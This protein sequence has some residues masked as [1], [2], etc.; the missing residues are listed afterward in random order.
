[1]HSWDDGPDGKKMIRYNGVGGEVETAYVDP[2]I[3]GLIWAM[4]EGLS[5]AQIKVQELERRI[6]K[7]EGKEP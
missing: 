6:E 3:V 4:S 1:M 2:G 5:M 7:L